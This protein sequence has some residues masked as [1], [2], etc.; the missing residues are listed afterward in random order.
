MT[1]VKNWKQQYADEV[2]RNT[3]E[4]EE[5]NKNAKII[6]RKMTEEEYQDAFGEKRE[7][8]HKLKINR[9]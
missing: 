6:T 9:G 5:R 3:L 4:Y 2:R 7:S 1:A 8:C